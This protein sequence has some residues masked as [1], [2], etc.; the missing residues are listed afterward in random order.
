MSNCR[1]GISIVT[2]IC[3]FLI[4]VILYVDFHNFSEEVSKNSEKPKINMEKDR[5]LEQSQRMW[6]NKMYISMDFE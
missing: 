6:F 2:L 1:T 3:L 5:K 4:A